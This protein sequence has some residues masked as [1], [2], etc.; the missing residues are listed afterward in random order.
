MCQAFK[1]LCYSSLSDA[2]IKEAFISLRREELKW[3]RSLSK[4]SSISFLNTHHDNKDEELPIHQ[5][6]FSFEIAL[7]LLGIKPCMIASNFD[8][9]EFGNEVNHHILTPWMYKFDLPHY[10]FEI[11]TPEKSVIPIG[12]NLGFQHPGF[13]NRKSIAFTNSHHPLYTSI[14]NIL[15]ED[16]V[17]NEDLG[18]ILGYPGT[19]SLFHNQ[20]SKRIVYLTKLISPPQSPPFNEPEPL[21][22]PVIQIPVTEFDVVY[23][24]S[25]KVGEHFKHVKLAMKEVL[26]IDMSIDFRDCS[27]WSDKSLGKMIAAAN[28]SVTDI[29]MDPWIISRMKRI[30]PHN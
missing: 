16:F 4:D 10:G 15:N 18:K 29:E 28:L 9:V 5:F 14:K 3:L 17:T 20:E 26:D 2:H 19:Q 12:K 25:V 13:G 1:R 8:F 24:E 30:L 22:E 7:T 11:I 21:P 27:N 23:Q 6:S